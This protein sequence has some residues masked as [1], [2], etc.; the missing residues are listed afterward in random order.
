VLLGFVAREVSL[1][2]SLKNYLFLF[3]ANQKI[4]MDNENV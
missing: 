1:P 4:I 3:G 2:E